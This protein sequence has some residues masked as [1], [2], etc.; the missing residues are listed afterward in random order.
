MI[1][2]SAKLQKTYPIPAANSAQK[3][4]LE[5]DKKQQEQILA[6]QLRAAYSAG[7]HDYLKLILNQEKPSEVQ[8]TITHYQYL[9]T[10]RIKEIETFKS[11]IT[12]L[13]NI[14]QQY[15]QQAAQ[16]SELTQTQS[17]QK[18]ILELSKVK[19]Q[20]TLKALNKKALTEQQKL[21]KLKSVSGL[22]KENGC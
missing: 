21:N 7:H 3:T 16:L 13:N 5:L 6:K 17:Q 11:T 8:R 19:Q 14:T 22:V 10:A 9:N 18:K 4:Q 20:Q 1:S 15:Q 2:L 12:Q